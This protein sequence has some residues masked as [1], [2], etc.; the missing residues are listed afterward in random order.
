MAN[1]RGICRR[2]VSHRWISLIVVPALLAVQAGCGPEPSRPAIFRLSSLALEGV[3]LRTVVVDAQGMA[4]ANEHQTATMYRGAEISGFASVSGPIA[5]S[6]WHM[7]VT[8]DLRGH[9]V[10]GAYGRGIA[11]PGQLDPLDQWVSWSA[12]G[13]CLPDKFV[14][15][16][17][18]DPDGWIM[19]GMAR[20]AGLVRLNPAQPESAECTR[21]TTANSPVN[22]GSGENERDGWIGGITPSVHGERWVGVRDD[23][24][25]RWRDGGTPDVPEDDQWTPFRPGDEPGLPS[26]E[27]N[28][29]TRDARGR[30]WIA[31]AG[32]L[33]LADGSSIHRVDE[34]AHPN[35]EFVALGPN[36][37]LWV[38]T[39][40]GISVISP[41]SLREVDRLNGANGLPG[42]RVYGIA[43]SD[44]GA[45]A[46]V[47]TDS[48]LALLQRL[49]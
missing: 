48:G 6:G 44:D 28:H 14:S 43:F 13:D 31:T 23:A 18:V 5:L 29:L 11:S 25:W 35:V 2:R 27:F 24:L 16:V 47:A 20:A 33:A 49:D 21:W 9:P 10:F 34:V 36:G 12:E 1:S 40:D 41:E 39:S 4:W 3:V 7:S 46:Y 22:L 15:M 19:A 37:Y 45:W 26:L 30:I 38:C 42:D 8:R 17:A 32:G